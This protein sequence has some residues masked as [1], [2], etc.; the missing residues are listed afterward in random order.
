MGGY[1][2]KEFPSYQEIKQRVNRV[3]SNFPDLKIIFAHFYFIS[4]DLEK[5]A[6]ILEKFK[7]VNFDITPGAEMFV[8]FSQ[9]VEKTR[10]FFIKYQNRIV[11]GT[12]VSIG[13]VFDTRGARAKIKFIRRFLETEGRFHM[14]AGDMNFLSEPEKILRGIKLPLSVLRKIYSKNFE[15][16][17]GKRPAK[18]D[19][20]LAIDECKR[21][22]DELKNYVQQAENYGYACLGYMR[23]F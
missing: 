8:N 4:Q 13:K 17:V 18:I 15:R 11:F 6:E 20:Q 1:F 22:G 10:Q 12:D 5:A 19:K 7:N 3:L 16:I 21:I 9:N 2:S 14:P 23:N